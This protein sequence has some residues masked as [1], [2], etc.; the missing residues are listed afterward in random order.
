MPRALT[1]AALVAAAAFG[2]AFAAASA[3]GAYRLTEC[4]D[5]DGPGVGIKNLTTRGVGCRTARRAA[6]AYEY[7]DRRP[8]GY[9]CRRRKAEQYV[10]DVRCTKGQRVMRWQFVA[11]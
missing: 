7:D 10:Y 2:P 5:V 8:S 4:G 3:E 1:I 9:S 11:D 6:R